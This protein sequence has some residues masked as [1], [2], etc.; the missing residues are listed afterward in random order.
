LVKKLIGHPNSEPTELHKHLIRL[1]PDAEQIRI[2]TTNFDRHFTTAALELGI[3]G[4][5]QF[6]APALPLGSDFSGI[7]HL[8][9]SVD[10]RDRDLVLTD[11]DFA[12]AYITEGWARRLLVQLFEKWV[13][14][15]VGFSHEDTV[16]EYLA[17]GLPP[18]PVSERFAL[19]QEGDDASRWIS[20]GTKPVTYPTDYC[21]A[22]AHQSL[23]DS[24]ARWLE[25]I[26][27]G[28]LDHAVR[29]QDLAR[30]GVPIR[31]TEDEDYLRYIIQ[32]PAHLSEFC[33]AAIDAEWVRWGNDHGL[34]DP[35]F[36]PCAAFEENE[37]ILADWWA[38]LFVDANTFDEM[39]RLLAQR[40][41]T[42]HSV[43]WSQLVRKLIHSYDKLPYR[44]RERLVFVLLQTHRP[45]IATSL[46]DLLLTKL[47]MPED[48][49][50]A[51]AV[52]GH[53]FD[54]VPAFTDASNSS[55]SDPWLLRGVDKTYAG[56]VGEQWESILHPNIELLAL[57]L[58]TITTRALQQ[59]ASFHSV[60]H[61]VDGIVDHTSIARSAIEP[62]EQDER[63]G[64]IDVL[65]DTARDSGQWLA[66]NRPDVGR[67][68]IELWVASPVPILR[69]LAVHCKGLVED[70]DSDDTLNWSLEKDLVYQYPY[71]HEVFQLLMRK[72]P[73]A[74]REAR[75]RFLE[76]T[77]LIENEAAAAH[78]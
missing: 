18:R 38:S 33:S 48:S 35:I 62:H 63:R 36:D 11:R 22:N 19:V 54:P 31:E 43:S 5:N 12:R 4:V 55:L 70:D 7:V 14:L 74:S 67:S 29:I 42:L 8:H 77:G 24:V 58:V 45:G 64:A 23:T 34:L 3:T 26:N 30:D 53:M 41:S 16:L 17:R 1:F 75:I 51:I 46:F 44:V 56:F 60:H 69:R 61:G 39:L 13:V 2:V 40:G 27:T 71:K 78:E 28:S 25:V 9:G 72:Y 65:I 32:T 66:C 37:R 68:L 6:N 20:R 47:K 15:F 21:A 76:A 50:I 10:G 49:R 57:P 59:I 52:F 73:I